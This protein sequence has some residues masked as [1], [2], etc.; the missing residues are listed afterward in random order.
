MIP[1]EPSIRD[2]SDRVLKRDFVL[3]LYS[4]MDCSQIKSISVARIVV[5]VVV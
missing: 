2:L 3:S 1:T 5:V 4:S